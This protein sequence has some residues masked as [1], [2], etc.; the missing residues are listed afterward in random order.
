M[1]TA[2]HALKHG[3]LTDKIIGVFYDVYNELGHG[4]LESVYEEA[5]TIALRQIGL[6]V[7]RQKPLVVRFRGKVVG[8]FKADLV[9]E[10]L[11]IL[12]L[13]AC[14]ALEPVHEAQILNYL[15]ATEIEL[16]LLFNFGPKPQFKRLIF[17]NI[18]KNGGITAVAPSALCQPS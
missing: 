14:R 16:G 18:R 11:L 13:K 9:V 1:S 10:S 4:F 3:E 12:D 17:D 6:V 2:D 5:M 15:R 8:E 7:E